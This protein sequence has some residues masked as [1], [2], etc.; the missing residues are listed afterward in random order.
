MLWKDLR[1]LAKA[2]GLVL[3]GSWRSPTS[4]VLYIIVTCQPGH[5]LSEFKSK[6]TSETPRGE[7]YKVVS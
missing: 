5:E 6:V 3:E 4:N 1:D 7:I 2:H